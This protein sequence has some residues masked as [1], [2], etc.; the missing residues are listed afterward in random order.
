MYQK[1]TMAKARTLYAACRDFI[2]VP[3]KMRPDSFMACHAKRF[4]DVTEAPFDAVINSFRYYNCTAETG[5][6]VAFYVK[7]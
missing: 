1:I 2:M 3:S 7:A 4:E 6:R 5:K